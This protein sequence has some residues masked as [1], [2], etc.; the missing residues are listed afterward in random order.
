MGY[1]RITIELRNGSKRSGVRSFQEPLNL[2][3]IRMHAWQLSSEVLGRQEIEDVTVREVPADD[4][5][6]VRL[7]L[8]QKELGRPVPRSTGQHPYLVQQKRRP[9]R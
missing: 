6:V 2:E 4:P 9:Q 8:S 1:V 7:I 3:E 5:A